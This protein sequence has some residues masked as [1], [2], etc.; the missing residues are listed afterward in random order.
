MVISLGFIDF[1][2]ENLIAESFIM[3]HH[4]HGGLKYS[5][6]INLDFD[7]YEEYLKLAMELNEKSGKGDTSING[8][9]HTDLQS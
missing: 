5:E 1:S 3:M 8:R 9:C 6:I 4:T 7:V 2:W